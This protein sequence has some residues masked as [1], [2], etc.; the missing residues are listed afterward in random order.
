MAWHVVSI[1]SSI[2]HT[3]NDAKELPQHGRV[4]FSFVGDSHFGHGRRPDQ[5]AINH[6]FGMKA[7]NRTRND[8][9]SES[10]RDKAD[11]RLNLQSFLHGMMVYEGSPQLPA[12]GN[13]YPANK[14]D[15]APRFS[16]AWSP[17]ADKKTVVR[18]G[19]NVV[20]T[21]ATNALNNDGQGVAPGPLSRSFRFLDRKL[22]S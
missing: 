21:N 4:V 18:A 5:R 12:G 6:P 17:G 16:F 7:L 15:F 20:Y 13:I 8:G 2:C 9:D 14:K 3:R 10:G 11:R 1:A 19:F 22:Q